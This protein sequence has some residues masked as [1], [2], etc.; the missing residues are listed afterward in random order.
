MKSDIKNSKK[1]NFHKLKE[2]KLYSRINSFFVIL[3]LLIVAGVIVLVARG[4]TLNLSNFTIT[5]T[6]ILRVNTTPNNSNVYLNGHYIGTSPVVLNSLNPGSYNLRIESN[7]YVAW[8]SLVTVKPSIITNIDAFLIPSKINQSIVSTD[9]YV[10]KTFY[11]Y[12]NNYLYIIVETLSKEY[13]V[14]YLDLSQINKSTLPI[15]LFNLSKKLNFNPKYNINIMSDYSNSYLLIE[16]NKIYYLYDVSSGKLSL[17]N[18]PYINNINKVSFAG[19]SEYIII[20]SGSLL[21]SVNISTGQAYLFL[22]GSEDFHYEILGSQ[23]VY[24]YYDLS[25]NET[26]IF[27]SNI[28]G[29]DKIT[30]TKISGKVTNLLGNNFGGYIVASSNNGYNYLLSIKNDIL[31]GRIKFAKN[32]NLVSFRDQNNYIILSKANSLYAYYIGNSSYTLI[33]NDYSSMYNLTPFDLGSYIF[34]QQKNSSGGTLSIYEQAIGSNNKYL[35][36][37]IQNDLQRYLYTVNGNRHI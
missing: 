4:Y 5:T 1:G 16:Y 19:S 22:F 24:T 21:G 8:Q 3:I 30:L 33:S 26:D 37:I 36:K 2:S 9:G 17:F 35:I 7:N 10:Y 13:K 6:G 18:L 27:I 15:Y 11:K 31:S 28:D 20:Q 32:Y 25:N 12:Q 29:T 23:I 14:Y 34:Y